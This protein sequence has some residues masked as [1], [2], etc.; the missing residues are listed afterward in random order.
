MRTILSPMIVRVSKDVPES[1]T[2]YMVVP[3]TRDDN[4]KSAAVAITNHCRKEMVDSKPLI[5]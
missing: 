2:G 4:D 3:C 5:K 1:S